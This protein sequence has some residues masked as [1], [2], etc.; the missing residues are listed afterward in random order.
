MALQFLSSFQR[1]VICYV[2]ISLDYGLECWEMFERIIWWMVA[3][4][5]ALPS[6]LALKYM[7][8]VGE[9]QGA[10]MPEC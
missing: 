6:V 3:A 5:F 10:G 1:A 7:P 4:T 2:D 9:I 8:G